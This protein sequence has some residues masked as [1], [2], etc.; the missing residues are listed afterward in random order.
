MTLKRD[1]FRF[2]VE[3]FLWMNGDVPRLPSYGIYIPQLVRFARPVFYM[4]FVFQVSNL[5]IT[6]RLMAQGYRYHRLRETFGSF[7][8]KS[9]PELL[10]KFGEISFQECVYEGISHTVFYGDLVYKLRRD[11]DA[12]NYVSSVLKTDTCLRC[13]LPHFAYKDDILP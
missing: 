4:R 11:Q 2:P 5:L 10:S 8:F 1:D 13:T 3:N 7:F 6:F 12:G 9:Y